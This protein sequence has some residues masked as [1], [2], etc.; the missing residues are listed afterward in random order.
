MNRTVVSMLVLVFG[1]SFGAGALT[2]TGQFTRP[3]ETVR[4]TVVFVTAGT[5][6]SLSVS[7][8]ETMRA[9]GTFSPENYTVSGAGAGT[10]TAHPNTVTGPL[11]AQQPYPFP[12]TD[13]RFLTWSSGEMRDGVPLTVTVTNVQDAVGNP[14]KFSGSSAQCP[15]KGIAP[16]LSHLAARPARALAGDEVTLSFTSSEPLQNDPVLTVNGYAASFTGSSGNYY[17]FSY[18]LQD[19]E[20][21]GMAAIAVSGFD[22][23]GNLGALNSNT[24]LEV[25]E[26]GMPLTAW[27]AALLMLVIGIWVLRRIAKGPLVGTVKTATLLAL[28]LVQAL[29]CQGA[30][31]AAPAI[32]N[33]TYSQGPNGTTATQVDIYFDLDAPNGPCAILV[34]LS[35]DG[36]A[37]G[38]MYPVTAITGDLAGVTTGTGWHIVWNIAADYPDED[39]PNAS[40]RL[41]ADDDI[42]QH[43]VAYAAGPNGSII[44]TSPQIVNHGD[45]TAAVTAE[46][47][48]GY[49]FVQWSDGRT[50]NPRTDTTV[51]T[52]INVTAT[53]AIDTYTVT[54]NVVG[55]GTCTAAPATLDYGSTSNI[56]VTPATG[57]HILSVVDSVDG[58]R[59]GSYTTSA[60]TAPRAVTATFAID[61]YAVTC[62]V[63]GNG[64]CTAAPATVDYGS[65]SN[66]TVT[67][68]TGWHIFSVVDS[69]DGAQAGSYTT[70]AITAPRTVTATFTIDTYAVTCNVVGNGTCT[71][72]PATV[73][74]GSTSN[75]TVTPA[76]GWHILSVV[77]SV[78]GAQAGSYT[79]SAITAPRSVTATF[80][81]DTYTVTC[82]VVGNG[83]CMAAPATVDYGGTSNVTVSPAI[84]WHIL[85]VV[86]SVDGAAQCHGNLRH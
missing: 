77:D 79:T 21:P 55:N 64:T 62:N 4:P 30:F 35:K 48:T 68:A 73:D 49:H 56:T 80:A 16:V 15:G 22:L 71:A 78:D 40:I 41:T 75:I 51:V 7:F 52:D 50:D 34:S 83:T 14:I 84:G 70:S 32:T 1:A 61:T 13:P 3:L 33:M 6:A 12:G 76:T 74:Y 29:L 8:S 69:V 53:F 47:D 37:D 67:P 66:I 59:A 81:I 57:W 23:A 5:T 36:G 18:V 10:L 39:M 85:S 38:Y 2:G 43:T 44:G 24:A 65:T 27:P 46:A 19:N 54:C 86:D 60:V 11:T 17:T 45:S 58:A 63:V 72:A 26:W 82:N 31:A 20:R 9:Q 25:L 42:V 28:F